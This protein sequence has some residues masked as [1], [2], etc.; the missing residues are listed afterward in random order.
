ME[1]CQ[2]VEREILKVV[3][4]FHCLG[5]ANHRTLEEAIQLVR[6][7]KDE[8]REGKGNAPYFHR[9]V[10]IA[11]PTYFKVLCPILKIPTH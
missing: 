4:K 1:A 8:I 11:K 9:A 3:E 10:H 2:G 5:E 6:A 7:A